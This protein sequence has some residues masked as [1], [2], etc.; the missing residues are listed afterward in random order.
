MIPEPRC[1]DGLDNDGDGLTDYPDDPGCDDAEDDSEQSSFLVCDNGLDDD[2]DGLADVA[3]DPGCDDPFDPFEQNCGHVSP[4]TDNGTEDAAPA[5]SD[6]KIAW[7]QWEAGDPE[8]LLWDGSTVTALTDNAL[9]DLS[10][11]M[12]GTML[13][14]E[15]WGGSDARVMRWTGSSAVPLSEVGL[16]AWSPHTDGVGVVWSQGPSRTLPPEGVYHW[17]GSTIAQVFGSAGGIAPAISG[18]NIVWETGAGIHMWNGT[19]TV[20]IPGSAGGHAPAVSGQKVVWHAS[21]GGDDEIYLWN[22]STTQALTDDAAED[23]NADI[24]G[25]RVVWAS[26]AGIEVWQSGDTSLIP[27]SAGGQFP[28]IDGIDVVWQAMDASDNEILLTRLCVACNDGVDNDGDEKIDYD[29]GFSALGYVA[30]EADPQCIDKPWKKSEA[31]YKPCGLC[32]E[33]ALLLPPLMWL[34]RRRSRY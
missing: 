34:W 2:G 9:W 6:S 10:P 11:S 16:D 15:E 12:A 28:K 22:G 25:N 18:E 29:G 30:A 31:P 14:W 32:A 13:V 1:S 21:D 23:R 20:L 17:D 5:V 26:D 33:L 3:E 4:L 7:H 8:I 27:G 24:S 19:T